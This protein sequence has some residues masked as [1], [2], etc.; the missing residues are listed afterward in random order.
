MNDHISLVLFSG[1]DD[2][3]T[4]AAT[5][6]T[7]AAAM[8]TRVNVL[9][10]FWALDSFRADRIDKDHGVTTEACPEG[11]EAL[12]RMNDR[13]GPRWPDLLRQ[14]KDIGDIRINACAHSMELLEVTR[15]DLDPMVNDVIGVA[16][17]MAEMGDGPVVFI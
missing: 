9:L 13:G 11:A 14:A 7:G 12:R 16:A 3:L 1:T 15:A 8:G 5:L 10:Q 4:A 2:K 6:A 17:F